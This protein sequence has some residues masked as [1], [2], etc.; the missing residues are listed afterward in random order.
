MSKA[1]NVIDAL[2]KAKPMTDEATGRMT[3]PGVQPAQ[4]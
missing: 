1:G 3:S 2:A 4:G